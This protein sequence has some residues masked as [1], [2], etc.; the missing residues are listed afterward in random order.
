[1]SSSPRAREAR[2]GRPRGGRWRG[3]RYSGDSVTE[4]SNG[5]V[6]VGGQHALGAH[7]AGRDGDRGHAAAR[8]GRG[9]WRRRSA[10]CTP[11]PRRRSRCRGRRAGPTR[12]C[13]P[14]ARP[15]P[16][17]APR[18][19]LVSIVGHTPAPNIASQRCCSGCSQN[20]AMNARAVVVLVA[21]PRVV[22]EHVEAAVVGADARDERLDLRRV[23]VV[24]DDADP[25]AAAGASPRRR[26]PRRCRAGPRCAR[27]RATSAR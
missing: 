3:P 11:W 17:A 25:G 22:D 1:M 23:G 21:A 9:P 5:L 16:A 20:G 18:G 13:T 27:P 15:R 19:A 8:A 10:R 6:L 26:R 7:E 2:R 24:A 4:R 14:R 12:W